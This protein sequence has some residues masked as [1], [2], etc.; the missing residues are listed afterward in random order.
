MKRIICIGLFLVFAAQSFAQQGARVGLLTGVTSI[1]MQNADDNAAKSRGLQLLPTYGFQFGGEF[2]YMFRYFGVGFQLTHTQAGQRYNYN[3]E[4]QKTSLRYIKPTLVAHFT[5]NPKNLVR[6]SGYV[7]GYFSS[8]YNY[9]EE[10]QTNNP[11]TNAISYS[12]IHNNE[13][14]VQDTGFARYQLNKGVYFATDAGLVAAI[15]ADF[16]LDQNWMFGI[17]TR[18]DYGMEKLE[19][20]E[21]IK[22]TT[23]QDDGK[24][25]T[26]DYEHWRRRRSKW[27][28][29]PG[30]NQ[31]RA[32][33]TNMSYGVFISLK[34][35]LL[36]NAV[37]EYERY[38]Y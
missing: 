15:G 30:Y 16:R 12:T 37:K 9:K 32:S 27:D 11:V 18:V 33:S 10:S 29:Q 36:S 28:Y 20:Y 38:G 8:L 26:T 14:T 13:Y 31:V 1:S 21:K 3:D 5:S 24:T 23:I 34:Y 19:N 6:F 35:I 2:A 17:H 25:F 7:G 4:F 22:L